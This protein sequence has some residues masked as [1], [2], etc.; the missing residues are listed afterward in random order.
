MQPDL[1][2]CG[3]GENV[4]APIIQAESWVPSGTLENRVGDDSARSKRRL[5]TINGRAE[6]KPSVLT[7]DLAIHDP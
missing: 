2:R 7:P 6:T 3:L 4:H 5:Q 1:Q